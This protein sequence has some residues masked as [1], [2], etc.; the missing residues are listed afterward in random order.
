MSLDHSLDR[1]LEHVA[2][3]RFDIFF[4]PLND[5]FSTSLG[6]VGILLQFAIVLTY[7]EKKVVLVI[8]K[9]L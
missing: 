9:N 6:R 7:C 5:K 2:Q 3:G 1:N 8:E 4:A